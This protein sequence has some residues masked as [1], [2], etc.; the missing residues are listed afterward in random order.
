MSVTIRHSTVRPPPLALRCA[1]RFPNH[2]ANHRNDSS[3]FDSKAGPHRSAEP[4]GTDTDGRADNFALL[5]RSRLARAPE[6]VNS[7]INRLVD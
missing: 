6:P 2:E 3:E 7:A 4:G 5:L 1:L